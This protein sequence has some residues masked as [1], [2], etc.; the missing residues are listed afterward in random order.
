L[1][2]AR[3]GGSPVIE[4]SQAWFVWSGKKPVLLDSDFTCWEPSRAIQLDPAGENLWATCLDLLPD[5][6]LEYGFIDGD[7]RIPDPYNPRT[8]PNGLGQAN[9]F[10]YMPEGRPTTLT[11]RRTGVPAGKISEHRLDPGKY[12]A[13][14]ARKLILYQP[15][16]SQA[17]PLLV[18][19]DGEDYHKRARLVTQVENLMAQGRIDPLALAML[20]PC[21]PIR[22]MEY[23]CSD[24]T[25][26]FLLDQV[27]PLARQHL[28]LMDPLVQPGA[29]GVMGASM[30]GL[31]A[32]YTALRLPQIFGRVLSQSGA[33]VSLGLEPLIFDLV[34]HSPSTQIKIWM[35]AGRYEEVLPGNRLMRDLLVKKGYPVEYQEFSSG[36][37]YPAWRNHLQPGLEWLFPF[38]GR[39][40]LL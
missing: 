40:T 26:G 16:V 7:R 6:Y 1:E 18:V 17:V 14:P 37:N 31:M 11:L 15:P 8:T 19:Y 23:A 10:F 2:R 32:L 30:G 12:L 33:Y 24:I 5:A 35:D 39:Y 13:G 9:H 28:S 21:S 22:T 20:Q 4:G 3:S 29:W 34:E 27:L 25:L 38:H 36:H